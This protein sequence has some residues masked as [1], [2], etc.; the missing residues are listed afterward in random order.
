MTDIAVFPIPNCVSFPGTLYPL[1]VFEPRFRQMIQYCV[2]TGTH[3]AVCHVEKLVRPAKENQ[4]L[5]E[6]LNSNQAVYKPVEIVSAGP[7]EIVQ[8]LN[9]GRMMINVRL[10]KRYRLLQEKQTLPFVVYEGEVF[11]DRTLSEEETEISW[12]LK[13]KLLHRLIALTADKPEL[14]SLLHSESWQ[15]KTPEAFSFELFGILHTEADI[16]QSILEMD[17]ATDRMNQ[18]LDLL[19]QV[20]AQL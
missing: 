6:A 16:M 5:S 18:A 17:S 15:H 10:S 2:D 20:P 19:N 13:D 12:Q 8:T 3:C 14:Q 4:P 1:H 9:D 11:A 7:V